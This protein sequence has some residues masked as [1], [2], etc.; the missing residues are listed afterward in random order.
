MDI[1]DIEALLHIK[2]PDWRLLRHSLFKQQADLE[3]PHQDLA[4]LHVTPKSWGAYAE[5]FKRAAEAIVDRLD[6]TDILSWLVYP[7]VFLY[8]QYLELRLKEIILAG[9]RVSGRNSAVPKHHR[10]VPLW[11]EARQYIEDTFPGDSADLDG[12]DARISE[13]EKVDP[14]A[15]GF[16]YPETKDGQATLTELGAVNL[17]HLKEVMRAVSWILDGASTGLYEHAQMKEEVQAELYAEFRAEY[18]AEMRAEAEA[19][20]RANEEY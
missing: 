2:R 10:L 15:E 16:R 8:R 17:V 9:Q 20:M 14:K 11:R 12:V 5:G 1:E 7:V 18:D 19:E 3:S 4:I 13:F 6:V